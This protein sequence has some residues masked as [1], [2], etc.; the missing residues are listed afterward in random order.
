MVLATIRGRTVLLAGDVE[1]FA[2]RELGPV[3][4][5]VLKVPHQGAATSDLGWLQAVGAATAVISVGPNSFGHPSADVVAAR[6][7]V[8]TEVL[9]TDRDGDVVIPLGP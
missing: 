2:Q 3:R 8:G 7:G 6:E 9:R 5:D 1:V 4:A